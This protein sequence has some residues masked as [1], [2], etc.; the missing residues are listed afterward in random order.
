MSY[1]TSSIVWKYPD[2]DHS[3]CHAW[4]NIPGCKLSVTMEILFFQRSAPQNE[5][6]TCFPEVGK[7]S[8]VQLILD[9]ARHVAGPS[10]SCMVQIFSNSFN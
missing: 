5:T 6:L 1:A 9:Q 10:E 4:L 7:L 3:N 2:S 8:H